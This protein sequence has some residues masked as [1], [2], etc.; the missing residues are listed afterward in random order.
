MVCVCV[1][2]ALCVCG[3]CTKQNG[4]NLTAKGQNSANRVCILLYATETLLKLTT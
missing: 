3:L 4:D 1:V 2:C